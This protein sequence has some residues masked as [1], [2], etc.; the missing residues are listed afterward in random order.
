MQID[1][2]ELRKKFQALWTRIGAVNE[3]DP[4]FEVVYDSYGEPH[5]AYHNGQHL[6]DCLTLLE[7]HRPALNLG[8]EAYDALEAA[9]WF[10]DVVYYT[11][12]GAPGISNEAL[13][14]AWALQKMTE[15]KVRPYFLRVVPR[16]VLSTTIGHEAVDD[17]E[18]VLHDIDYAILGA[19]PERYAAYERDVMDEWEPVVGSS[20][21]FKGRYSFLDALLRTL[22]IF[23]TAHFHTLL[24]ETARRNVAGAMRAAERLHPLLGRDLDAPNSDEKEE[25]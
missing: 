13:S 23:H 7:E 4:T 10:H 5:R 14:A 16:L 22:R 17:P 2:A 11:Q 24:D 9:I 8:F 20:A 25:E 6:V 18:R 1:K 12:S 19:A 3:A 21:Y 15:G